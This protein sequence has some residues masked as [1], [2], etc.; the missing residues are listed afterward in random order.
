VAILLVLSDAKNTAAR[1]DLQPGTYQSRKPI[2]ARSGDGEGSLVSLSLA[3]VIAKMPLH[4]GCA[5]LAH[6]FGAK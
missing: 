3:V 2:G 6:G 4:T 1:A 5:C